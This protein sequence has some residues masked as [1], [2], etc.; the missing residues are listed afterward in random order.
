MAASTPGAV[1]LETAADQPIANRIGGAWIESASGE[2]LPVLDPATGEC[3]GR[4]PLSTAAE[5]DRAVRA[6]RTA[7]P[8][9]RATP[10]VERARILFRL[11]T[12]LDARRDA[13]GDALSC[14]HGK[15]RA[16]ARA[17][18]QRGIE[19]VE[20]A[21]GI[22]T[23]LM[24]E[25]LEDI[26][27]GM[28]CETVRQPLGVFAAITPYNF[29]VMIPLWFWPYAVAAGN[30]FVL[31]P[32]EQDPLTHQHIVELA[33]QAGLPPGVLNVVH[34]A[35]DTTNALLD[36]PDV[37]GIS[38]VGSSRVARLVYARAA[39]TGKR[40]QALGGAK[41]HMIV[42]PDA[43]LDQTV[44][45]LL[46]S[47]FGA[48][49]QRCLAGSVVI[50]VGAAYQ[51]VR[52]RFLDGAAALR[53]G[54]GLDDNVDMGPLVS[55]RHRERVLGYVAGGE[56]EGARLV[57]D[58]RGAGVPRYPAGH[59]LGATVFENVRSH[60]RIGRE[61]IFGPVAALTRVDS[62]DDA[63][64]LMHEVDYGNATSIFTTS[65]RAARE[66]RYRA[67]ISMIGVNVG[68]AAPMAMFPFGGSRASF[69]GDL[70]AQGSDAIAFYTD[71]R[72]VISKW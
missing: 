37:Q 8:A 13:L 59:W 63:V 46:G 34:G 49:G 23:L 19:N 41:N 53:L 58:G 29:P 38:F 14:E 43:D 54:R 40:V 26:A 15:T 31:K 71:R 28:D 27:P 62:L 2:S 36:H 24:G 10:P 32:S 56:Q 11:K 3:L 21:C 4:V 44:N 20:H 9:W 45:A 1:L 65:G 52:E 7:F 17:E 55:A 6:A 60:M 25:T 64:R 67:G 66:F 68:V 57:L 22:P 33:E 42:L 12:L 72:V 35:M 39:A 50:G 48:A 16:E 51:P 30:T 70:K 47:L 5:V 61:E 18:V 69:Y